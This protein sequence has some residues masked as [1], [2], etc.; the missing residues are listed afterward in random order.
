MGSV[1]PGCGAGRTVPSGA[2][3]AL[4]AGTENLSGKRHL[5]WRFVFR[6][7]MSKEQIIAAINKCAQEVGRCPTLAEL[8]ELSAVT[9]RGATQSFGN[10]TAAV[11]PCGT[12]PKGRRLPALSILYQDWAGIVRKLKK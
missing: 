7:T 4:T 1:R 5:P 8:L 9:R 12:E 11:R 10:Y 3:N 2:P 6:R